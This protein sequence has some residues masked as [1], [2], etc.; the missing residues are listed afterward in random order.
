MMGL[1]VYLQQEFGNRNEDCA[2]IIEPTIPRLGNR[3]AKPDAIILKDNIFV[4]IDLKAFEGDIIA[5]C[6][7]GA[8]WKSKDGQNMQ[9]PGSR[10]PYDQS[11]FHRF[12][13]LDFLSTQF[14]SRKNVPA[15]ATV[16]D[17]T[18]RGWI[19]RHI[20]SWV[21]T[22]EG[23]RP[24]VTG[25]NLRYF[26]SFKVLPLEKVTNALTFLRSEEPLLSQ[27]EMQRFLDTLKATTSN[28]TEWYRG[29]QIEDS[30][31]PYGLIPKISDW[32]DAGEFNGIERALK[33][34]RDLDLK[35]HHVHVIR[36]WRDKR[37]PSLRK[38]ALSILMD[39]QDGRL[40]KILDEGLT[41]KDPAIVNLVLE[42]LSRF[43]YAETIPTLEKMVQGGPPELRIK[44]INAIG[45][46][47]QRSACSALLDFV[48]SNLSD[49]PFKD[50]QS[51]SD[52]VEHSLRDEVVRSE[53]EEFVRAEQKRRSLY[54]TCQAVIKSLG[55]LDCKQSIPWL[56]RII[57]E[58]ISM[59][60]ESNDYGELERI[61]SGY[62][63]IFATV[64]KSL[65]R[66]GIGDSTVTK[67]LQGR[68]NMLPKDYQD[69]I[70]L[71]L[72]NLGD[73]TAGPTL[74][75]FI[76]NQENQL[77]DLA[78]SALSKMRSVEAFGP[79]AEAYLSDPGS[80]SGRWTGEALA[81]INMA[82]FEELLIREIASKA[83]PERKTLFLET[84]LPIAS[85]RSVDTLFPLLEDPALSC[86]A[87][88]IL[89]NLASN[90]EVLKRAMAL[91]K[92][93]N[94]LVQ[95]SAIEV[96]RDSYVG[97]L[98][99]LSEFE[100]N[101]TPVEVLRVVTS[102]YAAAGSIDRLLRYT[103]HPDEGV[104]SNVFHVFLERR[105]S[106]HNDVF[107]TSDSGIAET[108]SLVIDKE[109]VAVKLKDRVLFLPKA[110]VSQ[111]MLTQRDE[112][113]RYGL[114]FRAK[115]HEVDETFIVVYDKVYGYSL[116]ELAISLLEELKVMAGT[117]LGDSQPGRNEAQTLALLWR[118]VP[119]N[120]VEQ[121]DRAE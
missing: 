32:I 20:R 18:M 16:D 106:Y 50:F 7:K 47:G 55:D 79:L 105:G 121:S 76:A 57:E 100:K 3:P 77:Y 39:W 94:P 12:A 46:S 58:P 64:C 111:A 45:A 120:S 67:L 78:V 26:P 35:R 114:C 97:N 83:D 96:L 2:I 82:R 6:S 31:Q 118:N 42:H 99:G 8:S 90:P 37:Y 84:L 74:L 113:D 28:I 10:N 68:L 117:N 69:D 91:V 81:N 19:T 51:W 104:R 43:G 34:I 14:V 112:G 1:L 92:S 61:H 13:L 86:W 109:G 95:A 119:P 23:S 110:T 49:K 29:E 40:G 56:K 102:I 88:W 25:I 59:G 73:P 38:E 36:V 85:L 116:R 33:H 87:S 75:P 115:R 71:A 80:D 53:Y 70:I 27:T 89:G 30:S 63:G 17:V 62:Y 44:V 65:G 24:E 52:R 103:D 22:A 101:D 60:F 66:V 9:P 11:G 41:D 107:I 5:D 54:E 93:N 15:W 108:C 4:L 98:E 21:V 48:L 72:G